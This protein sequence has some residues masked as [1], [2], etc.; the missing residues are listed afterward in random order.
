[1]MSGV[2]KQFD[3]GRLTAELSALKVELLSAQCAMDRVRLQYSAQDI[4]AFG[5]GQALKRIV[6]S[7][8]ALHQFCSQIEAQIKHQES[9]RTGNQ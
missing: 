7:A 1:M 6:A 3:V 5:E 4:V 2:R 9:E 8:Q